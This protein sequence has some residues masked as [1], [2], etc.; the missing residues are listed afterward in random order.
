MS[1]PHRTAERREWDRDRKRRSRAAGKTQECIERAQRKAGVRRLLLALPRCLPPSEAEGATRALGEWHQGVWLT[2]AAMEAESR[3]SDTDAAAA[4]LSEEWR[5]LSIE[6]VR[7]STERGDVEFLVHWQ[8]SCG[9][10]WEDTWEPEASFICKRTLWDVL[11]SDWLPQ[12]PVE[13]HQ[14]YGTMILTNAA[15]TRHDS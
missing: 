9:R 12:Q 3:V 15:A 7:G 4:A 2:Y 14:L 1:A 10:V 6:D 11:E 5:W 13:M 8:P